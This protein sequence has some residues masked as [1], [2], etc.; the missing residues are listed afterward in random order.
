MLILYA[1]KWA[2]QRSL[3]TTELGHPVAG[4]FVALVPASTMLVALAV[5]PYWRLGAAL[6]FGFGVVGW[7]GFSVW[8]LGKAL[9]GGPNAVVMTHVLY[10]PLVAGNFIATIV[11]AALG[12]AE[13][14]ELFFGA[15]LL[16][17]L[18]LESVLLQRLLGPGPLAAALRPTLGIA[19]APPSIGLVAYLAVNP[20][21]PGMVASLLLGYALLQALLLLRL[22]PWIR[23]QRFAASYWSVTFGTTG[24]ALA[25]MQMVERG[26]TGPA[27]ALA[28][29]LFILA[30][31]VI[32][33]IAIGTVVS[34]LG[35][36][37]FFANEAKV[38]G[39]D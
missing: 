31:F 19:L 2:W 4:G 8:H 32:G 37:L 10:L 13:W 30:N 3:A 15:G 18:A 34:L 17:W 6:L 21:A 22:W 24:V 16:S 36:R 33:S 7:L 23:Q 5:L 28:P 39:P 20:G 9:Q 14:G 1:A 38:V 25:A 11:T 26:A 35:G 27:A 29:G 12:W